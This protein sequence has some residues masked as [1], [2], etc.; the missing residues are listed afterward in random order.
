M[1]GSTSRAGGCFLTLFILLGFLY[2]LSIQN[3]L[4]GTLI[5]T[6]IGIL[7]AIVTWLID[8]RRHRDD[9]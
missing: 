3:P 5:G 2:G 7:F 1:T 6:G 8:R 9:D 4:K